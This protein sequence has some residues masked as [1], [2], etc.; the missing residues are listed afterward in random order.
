MT[1]VQTC[2]LP[3]WI[4]LLDYKTNRVNPLKSL[5]QEK[6]RIASL[7]REQMKIYRKALQEA[8]GVNVKNSYLY[9]LSEGVIIE[10]MHKM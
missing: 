1:G 4:V 2:A 7:Y 9:L 6:K 5:E 10:M 3:I 8:T